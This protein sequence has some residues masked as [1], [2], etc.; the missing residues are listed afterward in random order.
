MYK[1]FDVKNSIYLLLDVLTSKFVKLH[2]DMPSIFKRKDII[3][4]C[5]S[6]NS[7]RDLLDNGREVD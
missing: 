6:N 2:F 1:A 5:R 3:I 7:S 4:A